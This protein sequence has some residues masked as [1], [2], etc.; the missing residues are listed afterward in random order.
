MIPANW[1]VARYPSAR[2]RAGAASVAVRFAI[3]N[4]AMPRLSKADLLTQWTVKC[5]PP[6]LFSHYSFLCM[7]TPSQVMVIRAWQEPL[8]LAPG[9]HRLARRNQVQAAF[10]DI[11]EIVEILEAD[12]A[13]NWSNVNIEAPR[14]H[15]IDMHNVAPHADAKNEPVEGGTRFIVSGS[16]QIKESNGW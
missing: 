9:P 6:P 16:G 12:P 13:T 15:L 14:Q 10:T 7:A 2:K 1:K 5:Y 8:R 3:P 4:I 11:Q